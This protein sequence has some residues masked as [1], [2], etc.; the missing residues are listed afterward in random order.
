MWFFESFPDE[1]KAF[2]DESSEV[3]EVDL[4]EPCGS[5]GSHWKDSDTRNPEVKPLAPLDP[6]GLLPFHQRICYQKSK[7][8][9]ALLNKSHFIFKYFCETLWFRKRNTIFHHWFYLQR[10]PQC[11]PFM[12]VY[13]SIAL[14]VFNIFPV[15]FAFLIHTIQGK[16]NSTQQSGGKVVA[17]TYVLL[18]MMCIECIFVVQLCELY[19]TFSIYLPVFSYLFLHS[20][21]GIRDRKMIKLS[22]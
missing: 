19:I 21:M 1:Y 14:S 11:S 4:L 5:S 18:R 8:C 10:L 3:F 15:F 7:R 6:T 13:L 9:T 22:N 16:L 17:Y 2:V 12:Y 20:K